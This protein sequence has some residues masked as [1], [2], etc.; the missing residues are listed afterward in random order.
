MRRDAH[1]PDVEPALAA[2]HVAREIEPLT[3]GRNGG[4]GEARERVLGD[5]DGCG[6][7]P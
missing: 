2:R 5:L 6:L 4:M 1:A 3:V 7:A